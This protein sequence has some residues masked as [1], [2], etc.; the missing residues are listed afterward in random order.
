M[1]LH[2]SYSYRYKIEIYDGSAWHTVRDTTEKE[3]PKVYL[4]EI[5]FSPL[6]CERVKLTA[7]NY[8]NTSTYQY[9]WIREMLFYEAK[10]GV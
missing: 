3:A 5:S 10:E 1:I 8:W 9:L 6:R 7:G 4:D 2:A